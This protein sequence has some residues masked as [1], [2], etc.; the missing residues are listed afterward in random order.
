[1]DGRDGLRM[2]LFTTIRGTLVAEEFRCSVPGG[3]VIL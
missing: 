1:M 2:H 3:G